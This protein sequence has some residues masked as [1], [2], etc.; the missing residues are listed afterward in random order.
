MYF[1]LCILNHV[2]T[3]KV[4]NKSTFNL[5]FRFFKVATLCLDDSFAHSWHSLNQLHLECFPN[6][7]EGVPTYTG[8]LSVAFPSLCGPTHPKPSQLEWGW[9]I[10]EDMA[11]DAALHHSPSWSNSPYTAWRCVGS[12]SFWKTNDSPTKPKPDG[13]AYRCRRALR[14]SD[15]G[16]GSPFNRT[17]TL[18]TQPRQ[19]SSGFGTRLWMSLSVPARGQ[20]RTWSNISGETWK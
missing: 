4:L 16:E 18:S 12:L 2:V 17:T 6:R 1:V 3:Q 11:F 13:F 20:T 15:W 10:V 8:H 19:R 5:C 9:V 7:L 14:T